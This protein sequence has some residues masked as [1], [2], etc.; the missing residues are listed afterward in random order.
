[1]TTQSIVRLYGWTLWPIFDDETG[2]IT[3]WEVHS[4]CL[5]HDPRR[6]CDCPAAND[7]EYHTDTLAE[8]K[9]I[10]KRECPGGWATTKTMDELGRVAQ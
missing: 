8:A 6:L 4:P 5:K 7:G 9:A 3:Y 10:V 2:E 1:M